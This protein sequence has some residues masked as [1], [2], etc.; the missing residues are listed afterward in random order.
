MEIIRSKR[1]VQTYGRTKNYGPMARVLLFFVAFGVFVFFLTLAKGFIVDKPVPSPFEITG[2][3]TYTYENSQ[4]QTDVPLTQESDGQTNPS[5]SKTPKEPQRTQE[6]SLRI[7]TKILSL[8][9]NE[10]IKELPEKATLVLNTNGI[11]YTIEKGK[12]TIG[13]PNNPDATIHLNTNYAEFLVDDF[14]ATVKEANKAGG[15]RV[16][17]H[18]SYTTLT[19]KYRT[20]LKHKN[21]LGF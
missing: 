11:D 4:E 3:F 18:R 17:Q 21:C 19:W 6:E 5:P 12:V 2:A 14:C 10:V 7:N 15:F 20:M 8:S 9:K 13:T 1:K 16:E